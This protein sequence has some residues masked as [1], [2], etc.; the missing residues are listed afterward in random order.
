[1]R[2]RTDPGPPVGGSLRQRGENLV[3][4]GRP[5]DG[6]VPDRRPGDAVPHY[7][8]PDPLA[9][10]NRRTIT[11]RIRGR[12]WTFLTD[13]QVFSFREIDAGTL[14]LAERMEVGATDRVLDLGAGYGVLGLVAASLASGGSAVLVESSPRAAE[15]CEE[16]RRRNGIENARVQIGD[17]LGAVSGERF[18][19][20][21]TNPPIRAGKRVYYPWFQG[22]PGVLA[23]GGRLFVVIRVKQG[24]DSAV[25]ELARTFADVR[26]VARSAGY[27][28]IRA[29]GT[30]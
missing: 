27:H 7:F 24:A 22:A 21:V 4:R 1:M 30:P 2:P 23:P 6:G 15:L 28:V 12:E 13:T 17:G 14:L 20:V 10:S 18:D 11:A 5:H 19:L 9:P 26:T 25:K 16:N 29:T 8:A 3:P